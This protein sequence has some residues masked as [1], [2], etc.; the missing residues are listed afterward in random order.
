MLP[1][2]VLTARLEGLLGSSV[3]SVHDKVDAVN[4]CTQQNC[5]GHDPQRRRSLTL[6]KVSMSLAIFVLT[7]R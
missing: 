3:G 1:C 5:S 2:E 7:T 4:T 6:S